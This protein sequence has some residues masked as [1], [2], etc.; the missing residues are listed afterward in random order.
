MCK[1]WY[2]VNPI[3]H[4]GFFSWEKFPQSL[5]LAT[6][7]KVKQLLKNP[8]FY[9]ANTTS[10]L[11]L[12]LPSQ[13]KAQI[14]SQRRRRWYDKDETLREVFQ[15]MKHL[16]LLQLIYIFEKV[17]HL[18]GRIEKHEFDINKLNEEQVN[19][20]VN[21]VFHKSQLLMKRGSF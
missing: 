19:E 11:R 10:Q 7:K 9:Q 5:Q 2:D 4:E 12:L 16:S 3:V 14:L 1:R 6:A 8:K 21:D 15:K 20:L 18:K 13:I 17:I